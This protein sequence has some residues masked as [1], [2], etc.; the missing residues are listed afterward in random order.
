M[1][2]RVI[3]GWVLA[4]SLAFSPAAMASDGPLVVVTPWK[5]SA[6]TPAASGGVL[7]R[8][9]I[10]EPLTQPDKTGELVDLLATS[11]TAEEAFTTWRFTIGRTLSSMTA[12][13]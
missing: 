5:V 4:L 2:S 12:L 7:Q 3:A 1:C 13:L 9:G 11:W 8:M 6:L 10:T